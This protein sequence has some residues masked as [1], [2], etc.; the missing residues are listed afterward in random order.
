V[1]QARILAQRLARPKKRNLKEAGWD[2]WVLGFPLTEYVRDLLVETLEEQLRFSKRLKKDPSFLERELRKR[3]GAAAR[4]PIF[5]LIRPEGFGRVV[6]MSA[7]AQLGLL[8]PTGWTMDD[9]ALSH[10]F[11][12]ATWFPEYDGDADLARPEEMHEDLMTFSHELNLP[13]V[14]EA[15]KKADAGWLEAIRNELQWFVEVIAERAGQADVLIDRYD[16]LTY[17]KQVFVRSEGYK[18]AQ[19]IRRAL[20]WTTPP[21]SPLDR[22]VTAMGGGPT[23]P[24]STNVGDNPEPR[25]ENIDDISTEE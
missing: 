18:N 16:F 22:W 9:W 10:D 24:V 12:V 23:P 2:L 20:G 21:P 19:V 11:T 8:A 1:L 7:E 5:R 3:R 15:V 6:Q 14:I 25:H 17:F 13:T 4:H